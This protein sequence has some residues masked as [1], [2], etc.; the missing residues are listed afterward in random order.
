MLV[1]LFYFSLPFCFYAFR[2]HFNCSSI[3]FFSF[4][5][6]SSPV[7]RCP[8]EE[9]GE[10]GRLRFTR[11]AR[12]VL[13]PECYMYPPAACRVL[14]DERNN[15]ARDCGGSNNTQVG[16][17]HTYVFPY[18][19]NSPILLTVRVYSVYLCIVFVSILVLDLSPIFII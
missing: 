10:T 15:V 16:D 13:R 18:L 1:Y 12:G 6:F 11:A 2:F 19:A 8:G 5:L 9:Q 4:L 7:T 17:T 14:A 3:C